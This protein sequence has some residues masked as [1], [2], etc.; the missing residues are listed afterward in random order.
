V[1]GDRIRIGQHLFRF[2]CKLGESNH[3]GAPR[4]PRSSG[5]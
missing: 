3:A 2:E 1:D 4:A 5:S